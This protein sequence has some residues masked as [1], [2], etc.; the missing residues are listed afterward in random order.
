VISCG[1]AS[2]VVL[3]GLMVA[4]R[5]VRI[6]GNP[7]EVIVRHCTLVPGW[8]IDQQCRPEWGSE[9][10][11]VVSDI[12]VH[13][14]W[15]EEGWA[16]CPPELLTPTRICIDR[17]ILGSIVVQRDEVGAEPAR[18]EVSRSIVDATAKSLTAIGAPGDR[19]GQVVVSVVDSTVIGRVRVHAIELAENSIFTSPVDCARRQIGCMRYCYVPPRSRTPKRHACQP[20]AVVAAAA[21]GTEA[22]EAARVVP[23]FIDRRLRYGRPDYCRLDD[24]GPTTCASEILRG[25]DDQSHMGVFHDGYLPQRLD[26]LNAAVAEFLPLGWSHVVALES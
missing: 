6:S 20:D 19:R 18:L 16:D 24:I 21:P 3:D 12:A 4:R 17:S 5:A 7:R 2:R 23:L 25:A 26:S 1:D 11:L 15:R 14:P 9:P 22:V 10:S 8:D 13:Q